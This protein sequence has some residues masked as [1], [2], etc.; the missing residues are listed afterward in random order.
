VLVPCYVKYATKK[1]HLAK[2]L[3]LL[4]C[5]GLDRCSTTQLSREVKTFES[6]YRLCFAKLKLMFEKFG[7]N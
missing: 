5:A 3:K 4:A 7:P 1:A 2:V 6:D